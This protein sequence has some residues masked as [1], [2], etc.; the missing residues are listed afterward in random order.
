MADDL[1]EKHFNEAIDSLAMEPEDW[2]I[3]DCVAENSRRKIRIWHANRYFAVDLIV[4]GRS[5]FKF[6][7]FTGWLSPWRRRLCKAVDDCMVAK[8]WA[9]EATRLASVSEWRK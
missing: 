1:F 8:Q 3:T 4:G 5:Y 2:R 9:G 7:S 6:R